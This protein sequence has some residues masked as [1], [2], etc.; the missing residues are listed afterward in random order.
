MNPMDTQ[1]I[2]LV[3]AVF[4]SFILFVSIDLIF[5]LPKAGSTRGVEEISRA[6]ARHGGDKAGGMM[7][8]NILCSPDASA[9]VLLAACGVYIAGIPGGLIA[10]A[11]VFIGCRI[12]HDDN[13]YASATGALCTTFVVTASTYIGFSASVWIVAMVINVALIQG[14]YQIHA[15]HILGKLW[16]MRKGKT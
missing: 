15:S 8:G 2:H 6:I 3:A 5:N 1:F 9:G 12:C 7:M 13:W 16:L 4:M 11:F 10:A 14:I